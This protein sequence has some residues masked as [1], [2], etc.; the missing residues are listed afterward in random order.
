MESS[1]KKANACNNCNKFN[2]KYLDQLGSVPTFQIMNNKRFQT[3]FGGV[4]TTFYFIFIVFIIV[5]YFLRFT[6]RSEPRVDRKFYE[7]EL[8]FEINFEEQQINWAFCGNLIEIGRL[9]SYNE[10]IENFLLVA[11]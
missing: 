8:Q 6:D 5:F 3:Q 7:T 2:L 9:M 1:T 11:T 4:I 10:L